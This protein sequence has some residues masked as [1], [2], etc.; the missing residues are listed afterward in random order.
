MDKVYQLLGLAMRAGKVVSGEEQVLNVVRSGKAHLVLLS[1]DASP[2]THKKITDK[3]STYQVPLS[4][5]G[6]RQAL[7]KA[8]G[9]S[10]RVV[11]AVTDPGFSRAMRNRIPATDGGG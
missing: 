4:Q 2:N 6:S 1:D 3:C 11:I 9:K 8:V 10:E 7:G 5:A